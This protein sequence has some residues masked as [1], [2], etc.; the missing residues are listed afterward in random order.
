MP[1][2]AEFDIGND[3]VIKLGLPNDDGTPGALVEVQKNFSSFKL[4][5]QIGNEEI[6]TFNALSYA[7]KIA[8]VLNHMTGSA[9]CKYDKPFGWFWRQLG[10]VSRFRTKMPMEI[11]PSGVT[12][13]YEKITCTIL[14][15][16]RD[17]QFAPGEVDKGSCAWE[18]TGPV[19]ET[20][21]P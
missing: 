11:Y 8:Y 6:T 15:G 12:S 5:E 1:S 13:G 18:R 4:G 16:N 7:K 21:V 20:T 17:R 2:T 9:D 14:L 3:C 10:K 19:V